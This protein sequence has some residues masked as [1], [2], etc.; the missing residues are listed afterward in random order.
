MCL[1]VGF[2][3]HDIELSRG[4]WGLHKVVLGWMSR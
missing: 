4:L 3:I 1:E 2:L